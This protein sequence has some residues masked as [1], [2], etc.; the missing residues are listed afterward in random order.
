VA[1]NTTAITAA[2]ATA[3]EVATAPARV[4]R[5]RQA[6]PVALAVSIVVLAGV[7]RP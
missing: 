6:I 5:L 7:L 2:T 4:A 1:A 3:M